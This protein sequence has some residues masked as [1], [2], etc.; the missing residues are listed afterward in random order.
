MAWWPPCRGRATATMMPPSKASGAASRMNW[1]TTGNMPPAPRWRHRSENIEI[2]YNRQRRQKRLGNHDIS[3]KVWALLEPHLPDWA[4]GVAKGNRLFVS[5]VFWIMRTGAL[6]RDLPPDLGYW[7]RVHRRFI[8][9]DK[10]VWEKLR[11]TLIDDLDYEGLMDDRRQPL[12]SPS[13]CGGSQR[14]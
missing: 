12:Q 13:P 9:R 11:E 14:R 5:A 4:E 6:W 3:D 1:S 7:S 2:F 10:S 8:R